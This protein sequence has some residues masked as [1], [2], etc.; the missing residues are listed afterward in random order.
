M[1]YSRGGNAPIREPPLDSQ[2][3]EPFRWRF[4]CFYCLTE[5][6]DDSR[7]Q[8]GGCLVTVCSFWRTFELYYQRHTQVLI[9]E[10]CWDVYKIVL[11]S[12]RFGTNVGLSLAF[13]IYSLIRDV[14][15]SCRWLT[16][17]AF[18]WQP[19]RGG[20]PLLSHKSRS[21]I[22]RSGRM[23]TS[24]NKIV[25]LSILKVTRQT[26]LWRNLWRHWFL[27]YLSAVMLLD[28]NNMGPICTLLSPPVKVMLK[29]SS[30]SVA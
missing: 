29:T 16:P 17:V 25:I 6:A 30:S 7:L 14:A 21:M 10:S 23:A 5:H 19:G 28:Q 24:S 3:V 26:L 22:T 13:C 27:C 9:V 4:C 1:T 20:G 11:N 2:G 18:A 15:V 8:V 12:S